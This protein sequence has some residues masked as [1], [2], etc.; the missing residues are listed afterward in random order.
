MKRKTMVLMLAVAAAAAGAG[1][2]WDDRM[3]EANRLSDAGRYTEAG[4]LY[5]A[6]AEEAK[7]FPPASDARAPEAFNNLGAHLYRLG[8]YAEAE[9]LYRRATAGWKTS[10]G[11]RRLQLALTLNNLA[12]LYRAQARWS[13]AEPLYRESLALLEK[14]A[15]TQSKETANTLNNL[16]ELYR[17]QGRL[18]EAAAVAARQQPAHAGHDLPRHGTPGGSPRPV[19]ARTGRCARPTLGGAHP[20][21]AADAQQP[22]GD[23]HR[24]GALRRSRDALAPR[25]RNL[26]RGA[27][28]A[29]RQ[30][31]RGAE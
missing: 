25:A 30:R 9:A 22:G 10:Q 31:G 1:Q 15:G 7:N 17:A 23:R 21:V 19:R 29:A 24:A 18:A 3:R 4:A 26:A 2:S 5:R 14:T 8:Q 11:D 27:R 6:A 20:L 13:E 16:A 28:A 12:A